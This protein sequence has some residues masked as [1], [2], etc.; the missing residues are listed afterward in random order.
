[1]ISLA[2]WMTVSMSALSKLSTTKRPRCSAG[3]SGAVLGAGGSVGSA[4]TCGGGSAVSGL[5]ATEADGTGGSD[6]CDGGGGGGTV[7]AA[8]GGAGRRAGRPGVAHP[9]RSV[10]RQTAAVARFTLLLRLWR[11]LDGFARRRQG[12]AAPQAWRETPAGRK[13]SVD[14]RSLRQGHRLLRRHDPWRD[15]T[16]LWDRLGRRRRR[17]GNAGRRR[18]PRSAGL[19]GLCRWRGSRLG[20][21]AEPHVKV[22]VGP[23]DHHVIGG[24]LF[25]L[26][27]RDLV[28]DAVARDPLFQRVLEGRDRGGVPRDP[29]P[30]GRRFPS[31]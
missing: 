31:Q 24:D 23:G 30:P 1:M 17:S 18:L 25:Q 13:E 22:A 16:G 21:I 9:A 28:A 5:G 12:E 10:M 20:R 29:A 2:A 8:D 4:S 3:T 7:T 26:F 11:L 6:S 14:R 15:Q 27:P 19:P